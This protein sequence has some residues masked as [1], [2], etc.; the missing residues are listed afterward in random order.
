MKSRLVGVKRHGE[1]RGHDGAGDVTGIRVDP[2]RDVESDHRP[3]PVF[4]PGDHRVHR[5]TRRAAR[6]R[7]E[8]GID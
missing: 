7:T 6:A 4:G 1:I 3:G 2:R 5:G 8:Q